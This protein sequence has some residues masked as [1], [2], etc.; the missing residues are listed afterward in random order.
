MKDGDRV[1][2]LPEY[3]DN[4]REIF[5]VSQCDDERSRCWIADRDGRGWYVFFDQLRLVRRATKGQPC[6]PR[7]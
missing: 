3:A 5:T 4:P 7:R 1:Q 2:L 6:K